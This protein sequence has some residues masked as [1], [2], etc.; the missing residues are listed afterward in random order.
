MNRSQNEIAGMVQKAARGA[1]APPGQAED[2]ARV[3]VYLV[4]TGQGL[5]CVADALAE[6]V[7]LIDVQW[8]SDCI[9]V[10]S[11]SAIMV[12]PVVR[13]AFLT[14]VKSA[15]LD[16]PKHIAMIRAT[17]AEAGIKA[18]GE[19]GDLTRSNDAP[20]QATVSGPV[21]IPDKLWAVLVDFAAKTYVPETDSSR[22]SG[23][24]AGLT[25]ND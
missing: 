23:A 21:H 16:N 12:A 4:Q 25:D 6:Q 2:L 10:K 17:L 22:I 8:D 1:G 20:A 13:D 15:R 11:G 5:E 7:G 3:A 19:D 24:G 18:A 14:G 9:K